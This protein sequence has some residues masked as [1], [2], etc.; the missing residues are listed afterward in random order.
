MRTFLR[1]LPF[2]LL[3][4]LAACSK[5]DGRNSVWLAVTN[6]TGRNVQ[7]VT[8][9]CGK[10]SLSYGTLPAGHT[11]AGWVRMPKPQPL[12]LSFTGQTGARQSPDVGAEVSS[13]LISGRVLITLRAD[14]SVGRLD[15]PYSGPPRS[16]SHRVVGRCLRPRP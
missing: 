15:E 2:L 7:D 16:L 14:G 5:D 11:Q 4:T 3:S 6:E 8:L 1:L 12:S 9:V 13:S 10:T